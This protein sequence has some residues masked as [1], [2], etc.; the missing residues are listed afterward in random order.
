MAETASFRGFPDG[1]P[2]AAIPPLGVSNGGVTGMKQ[3]QKGF[4]LVEIAIVLASGVAA[5]V[6]LTR[7]ARPEMR[8]A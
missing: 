4:T 6:A 3:T 1:T 7:R 2:L 8:P 5:A